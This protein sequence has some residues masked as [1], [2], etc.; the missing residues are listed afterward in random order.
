MLAVQNSKLSARKKI[1][2]NK[3][4]QKFK[5]QLEN[6]VSQLEEGKG[7]SKVAIITM[8]NQQP[9]FEFWLDH[10]STI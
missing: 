10:H 1:I 6:F 5:Q 9:N 2:K 3:N 8:V 4:K 7:D